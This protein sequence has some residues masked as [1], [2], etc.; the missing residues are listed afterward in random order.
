MESNLSLL[1]SPFF[2]HF[3]QLCLSS[4]GKTGGEHFVNFCKR[5]RARLVLHGEDFSLRGKLFIIKASQAFG[6]EFYKVRDWQSGEGEMW[7]L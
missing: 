3:G 4:T 2:D 7:W 6:L 5:E 1:P